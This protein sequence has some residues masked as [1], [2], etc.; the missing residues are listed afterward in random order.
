MKIRKMSDFPGLKSTQEILDG[1]TVTA[2]YWRLEGLEYFV[3][4]RQYKEIKEM[5][6]KE[7]ENAR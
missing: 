1:E 2:D 4:D 7:K 6:E 5:L 3:S